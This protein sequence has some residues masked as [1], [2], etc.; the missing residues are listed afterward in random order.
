MKT[1]AILLWTIS[2]SA[3]AHDGHGLNNQHWHATDT[4]G[5]IAAAALVALLIWHKRGGK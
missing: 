4:W 2:T 3:L 1:S 5:F